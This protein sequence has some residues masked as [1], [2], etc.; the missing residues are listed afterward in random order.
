MRKFLSFYMILLIAISLLTFLIHSK[1]FVHFANRSPIQIEALYLF[2]SIFTFLLTFVLSLL[3]VNH[4]FKDQIGFLYLA[5]MVLKLILFCVFFKSHIFNQN[6]FTN[7]ESANL[8]IPMTL[9]LFFEILFLSKLL[10][11]FG[12]LKND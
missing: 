11:R 9:M 3:I 6:S 7:T 10:N 5:S 12:A 1:G 4:K 8:L 2:H